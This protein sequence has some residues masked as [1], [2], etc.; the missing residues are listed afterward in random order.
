MLTTFALFAIPAVL[1]AGFESVGLALVAAA[2]VMWRVGVYACGAAPVVPGRSGPALNDRL[3]IA[4]STL[5]AILALTGV[6]IA[7]L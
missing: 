2:G 1:A 6:A 3:A 7:V 4:L 5:A